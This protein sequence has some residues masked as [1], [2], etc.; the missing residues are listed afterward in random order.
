MQSNDSKKLQ[1]V[2]F[3]RVL[4]RFS[5]N[6]SAKPCSVGYS[7]ANTVLFNNFSKRTTAR[8]IATHCRGQELCKFETLDRAAFRSLVLCKGLQLGV[9][10]IQV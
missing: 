5:A 7:V 8:I 1:I 9:A 6:S 4:V 2:P 3:S 10:Q